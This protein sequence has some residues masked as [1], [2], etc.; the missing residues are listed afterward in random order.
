MQG[1]GM[2]RREFIALLGGGAAI[3]AAGPARG[4]SAV[5]VRRIGFLGNSTS[6]L[7]ANLVGPFRRALGGL[8]YV[9][10]RDIAIEYRWADG[11]YERFPALVAEL[12]ASG[13]DVIVTAGTP[14]AFAVKRA[15][16]S[17]PC[18][19]VAVG[20]PVGTGLVA[21]LA[22]PG[23]NL[24]GLT[25]IA[26]DLEG[27]RLALLRE[28]VPA[29]SH[30]AVL[31]NPANAFHVAAV[32]GVHAAA[33]DMHMKVLSLGVRTL[34]E[35][36]SAFAAILAER[37]GA[38]VVLADRVFLH[39]RD[40]IMTFAA[41]QR[42]PGVYAYRELVEAGGL[43]SYGPNYSEMHASAATFVDKILKGAKPAD[44]PIEQPI[45]FEL[46]IN[47]KTAKALGIEASPTLLATADEL[48]E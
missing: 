8:G 22:R 12:I 16:N 21:S 11:N 13:V 40:R 41:Q 30:F 19:M 29:L 10:G 38:L 6:A 18:V 25:S 31:W 9:E 3:A 27:K 39:G 7:E 43:M 4:Q 42:L 5:R 45:K 36:D 20:D 32:E 15:T 46:V 28:M 23:G 44:L 37:P 26:P 33:K 34:D 47:M 17:I 48:L 1:F 2:K 24:T 14:A 35:L